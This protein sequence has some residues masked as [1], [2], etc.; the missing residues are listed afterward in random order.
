[1][2]AL[3]FNTEGDIAIITLNRPDRRNAINSEVREGLFR[4]FAEF[5][6]SDALRVAILTG[7]GDKAFCAGMDL[8]EAAEL[9]LAVPPPGYFPVL[10]D[11]VRVSKP[12][13]AAVNGVALAGGWMFAQMCDLCLASATASF[14]ITEAKVGRGMP[15]A[16]PL[17]NMIPQ[18]IAME[19]LMTGRFISAQR[20]Y[21]IGFVNEVTSPE[22]LMPKAMELAQTIAANAPLTV[23]AVKQSLMAATEM[24]RSAALRVADQIF[25]PV[26]SCEDAIEGPKAFREKRKPVWKG[27]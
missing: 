1:M 20:A 26:Y 27:R 19:L 11:N 17:V 2:A 4:A 23:K 10:G 25:E 22:D 15:W 12:V 9:R 16:T 6:S 24:G 18:R 14:G 3:E 21:E 8:A 13:I 5:E 7:A